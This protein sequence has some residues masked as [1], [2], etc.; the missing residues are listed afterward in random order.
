MKISTSFRLPA[1]LLSKLKDISKI[2]NTSINDI[3]CTVL[4]NSF[5]NEN[6][7]RN[8]FHDLMKDPVTSYLSIF[9]KL[10]N[11]TSDL[12]KFVLDISELKFLILK[13]FDAYRHSSN[14][15]VT[16]RYFD[17]L[18]D[19]SFELF[20]F[21]SRKGIPFDEQYVYKYLDLKR[22]RLINIDD[23]K[24]SFS[25]NCNGA[26]A[27]MLMRP[28]AS[29]AFDFGSYSLKFLDSVFTRERLKQLLPVVVMG[30]GTELDDNLRDKIQQETLSTLSSQNISLNKI[31]GINFR[32]DCI[33]NDMIYQNRPSMYFLISSDNIMLPLNANEFLSLLRICNSYINSNLICHQIRS[34]NLSLLFDMDNKY[35]ALNINEIRI[36]FNETDFDKFVTMIAKLESNPLIK[37]QINYFRQVYGDI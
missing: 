22:D 21:S 29:D 16:Q 33:G 3:V 23:L 4:F 24:N 5:E 19:F 26:Y 31:G 1:E 32:I 28:I 20:Q 17:I 18:L 37:N 8:N 7:F 14:T 12:N 13:I 36:I 27:E 11:K 2:N 34:N 6:Y 10:Q 35:Y 25:K 9:K 15:I 30:L